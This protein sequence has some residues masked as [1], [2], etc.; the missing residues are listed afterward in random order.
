MYYKQ[1]SNFNIYNMYVHLNTRHKPQYKM[2][3]VEVSFVSFRFK[4]NR[5]H[6]VPLLHPVPS[7]EV[8]NNLRQF[9]LLHSRKACH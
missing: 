4:F 6:S 3:M 5:G 8:E 9:I 2:G 7:T 1:I